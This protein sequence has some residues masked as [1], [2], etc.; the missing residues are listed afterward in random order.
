VHDLEPLVNSHEERLQRFEELATSFM[1]HAQAEEVKWE[2]FER[3][4][5][6]LRELVVERHEA[7]HKRL[8]EM[9]ASLEKHDEHLVTL[10][11]ERE[12][13]QKRMLAFRK[14]GLAAFLAVLGGLA[15]QWGEMLVKWFR[16]KP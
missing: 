12:S 10:M 14:V 5:N 3:Q 7:L 1:A 15:T 11:S 13:F 8:D 4:V 16:G 9:T 6:E 2:S